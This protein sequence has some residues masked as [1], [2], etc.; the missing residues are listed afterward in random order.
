M[1]FLLR[2]LGAV[3]LA[4]LLLVCVGH[5]Q[6]QVTTV[7]FLDFAN[8]FLVQQSFAQ[9]IVLTGANPLSITTGSLPNAT[10]NQ[11]YSTALSAVGGNPPYTWSI[12]AGSLPTGT[13]INA[14]TGT[15]S[16]TPTVAGTSSFTATVQD[17]AGGPSG[18]VTISPQS[19]INN[20]TL[21]LPGSGGQTGYYLCVGTTVG[22]LV[23]LAHC[24]GSGVGAPL[25]SATP[26]SL[27]FGP[28][29][30]GTLSPGWIFITNT[31]NAT[32][33]FTGSAFTFTGTNSADFVVSST[34]ASSCVNSGSLDGGASCKLSIDFTPGAVGARSATLNIAD[35]AT[36]SPQTV[37]LTGTG[38]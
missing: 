1:R 14:T 37:A 27:D 12:T 9:G 28:V 21:V 2:A 33:T 20:Y 24:P 5:A 23:P 38:T 25:V 8:M 34:R 18:A 30:T 26:S 31:G 29:P 11:S 13:T 19:S 17:T 4:L 22:T 15:I 3:F 16:G 6:N 36:G 7:A 32:L 10:A 35:N